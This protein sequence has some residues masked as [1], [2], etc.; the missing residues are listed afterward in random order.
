[1]KTLRR[2]DLLRLL[3]CLQPRI[4]VARNRTTGAIHM[5]TPS[6]RIKS[7][8]RRRVPDLD[9]AKADQTMRLTPSAKGPRNLKDSTREMPRMS[10]EVKKFI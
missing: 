7:E 10:Q 9:G 1:M 5:S 8:E 6:A 2:G 3:S 4:S